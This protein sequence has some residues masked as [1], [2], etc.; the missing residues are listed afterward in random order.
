MITDWTGCVRREETSAAKSCEVAMRSHTRI[1]SGFVSAY[2]ED[3][4]LD[5]Y[6]KLMEVDGGR[7]RTVDVDLPVHYFSEEK[8]HSHAAR[9]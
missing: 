8:S 7:R 3:L 5:L 2:Y 9:A 6:L 4:W 1:S